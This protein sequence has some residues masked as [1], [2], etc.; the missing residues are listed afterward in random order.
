MA[1]VVTLIM[2]LPFSPLIFTIIFV[3]AVRP[4]NLRDDELRIYFQENKR[5]VVNE[6]TRIPL[7]LPITFMRI[8]LATLRLPLFFELMDEGLKTLPSLFVAIFRNS[9]FRIVQFAI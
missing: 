8:S 3:I 5:I 4:R 1:T 6:R 7:G 9:F 2:I